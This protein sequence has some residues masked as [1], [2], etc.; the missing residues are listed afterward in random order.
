MRRPLSVAI[1][2]TRGIPAHYGGFE[3]FAE[4]IACRLAARGWQVR[5][6]GR[7]GSVGSGALPPGVV[8]VLLPAVKT[9]HLET[10]SHT[11][12]SFLH[13]RRHPTDV[14]LC[15]NLANAPLLP[16]ATQAGIP[17]ALL[18]D[19]F[20]A[21]RAKWGLSGR[22]WLTA[23]EA[24]A[25]HLP[26]AIVADAGVIERYWQ[27]KSAVPVH[28]IAYGVEPLSD[29]G[30]G[31]LRE[32]GL[33][34]DG[35]FL[36]VS[37]LE[38]EN[39]AHRVIAAYRRVGGALP[40]VIV[41][42][43]PY[44]QRYIRRLHRMADSR[45]RFVGGRYGLAYRQLQAHCRAYIHATEVGGTHPAL[46]EGLAWSP[47]A[48]VHDTP[49]NREVAADGGLYFAYRDEAHLAA[50]MTRI[51]D[52]PAHREAIRA[53]AV[54]RMREHYTW[55]GVVAAYENLLGELAGGGG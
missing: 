12:L 7:P 55:E 49:E 24:L 42:H 53:R 9:K 28:R 19:G 52:D 36:Y 44:A 30:D 25:R 16:L 50:C 35:Y 1:L 33:E 11:A 34:P 45:V 22:G 46:L 40:L 23:A 37:R 29:P 14:A 26:S 31:I 39:N 32:L 47:L 2:G 18:V 43:A 17:T 48:I 6:Y 38:P 51:A 27:K 3:T 41:G 13:L 5:V 21:E 54:A 10:L 20:E 8:S 15:C 4:E